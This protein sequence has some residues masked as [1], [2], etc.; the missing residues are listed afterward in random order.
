MGQ[1]KGNKRDLLDAYTN[2]MPLLR[3]VLT[4]IAKSSI[5]R[6]LEVGQ[7]FLRMEQVLRE[8]HRVLQDDGYAVMVL[9]DSKVNGRSFATHGYL[10]KF[11][12]EIGFKLYLIL[13]DPIRTRGMSIGRH[14]TGGL[15]ENEFV[16]VLRR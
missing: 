6:A 11:A 12:E 3:R 13:R 8:M 10:A 2:K 7:Y 16:L 15:I 9:G 1:K 4:Q 5:D 14:S